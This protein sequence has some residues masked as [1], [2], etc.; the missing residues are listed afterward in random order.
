MEAAAAK[1]VVAKF[2]QSINNA[3]S[4]DLFNGDPKTVEMWR[5]A[6]G[7]RREFGGVYQSND[8]VQKLT[9]RQGFGSSTQLKVD[10]HDASNYIFGRSN[11]GFV[12]RQNLYRGLT[13]LKEVLGPDSDGWARIRGEAFA[14]IAQA[15]EGPMEAGAAQFSGAKFSTAWSKA[16]A[17][18]P[19]LIATLFKPEEVRTI[20]KFAVV[21]NRATKPVTGGDNASN[22]AVASRALHA[23]KRLPFM[24]IE[25]TPFIDHLAEKIDNAARSRAI[26]Q[27]T[28]GAKPRL[29][30]P[31][32][33]A[34]LA[35][36]AT[37][38]IVAGAVI[39]RKK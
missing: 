31:P 26:T 33:S 30:G 8:L 13:K 24:A 4:A 10:A 17:E 18:D 3:M 32:V 15:G 35:R 12:G 27:A 34:Q 23:F 29:S 2:D 19:N 16:K 1:S 28:S 22:T 9:E 38:P 20:D 11:L 37:T 6:I 14:R 25:S 5:H 39:D 7:L 36:F 21:A